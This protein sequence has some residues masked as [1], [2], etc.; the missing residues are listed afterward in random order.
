MMSERRNDID[1]LR[2]IA[3]LAVFVFHCTRFFDPHEWH[4]KNSE[5]NGPI[6]WVMNGLVWP[7]IMELF[8]LVSGVGAFYALK[9]RT[10]REYI[11][12]RVKRLLIPL[13]TVG[14]FILLPPQFYFDRL[15]KTGYSGDFLGIIPSYFAHL[16]PPRISE[17]PSTLL[18]LPF[19]GH[20]WFLQHL[21][22]ISLFTLP[23][24]LW[25]K[26]DRGR[27]WIT[28]LAEW[29]NHRGGVF[30]FA[31]P[32]AVAHL[33]MGGLDRGQSS[34]GGFVWYLIYFVTGYVIAA[35]KRFT[36]VFRRNAPLC[37]ALW[38]AGA[39]VDL[40]LLVNIYG[41]MPTGSPNMSS[42]YILFS[43]TW[44]ICSWSAVIFLL[45]MAAGYLRSNNKV[46][47]YG[48]EAVLPFYLL[49]QTIILGVGFFVIRW[50]MGILPK[51][52]IIAAISFPLVLLL[53]ELLVRRFNPMRFL[54]G[55]RPKKK[56]PEPRNADPACAAG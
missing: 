23:L 14:L 35:E 49:H 9:S 52:L 48:N 5:Q 32:L 55:M 1:W 15:T 36:E 18:P 16:H 2:V 27:Q 20:L 22:L 26:S 38:L 47:N 39:V 33:S 44:S 12:E 24:L 45:G 7:W 28:T 13:Y 42:M 8:F 21:F 17:W 43:I 34:W 40:G 56:V 41:Y 53:Y 29:C 11:L 54:F 10:A 50:N 31:I 37:L 51:F 30:L 6:F 19:G 4:L 3:M 25:L 46:L